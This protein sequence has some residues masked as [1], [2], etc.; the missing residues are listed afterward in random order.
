MHTRQKNQVLNIIE[1]M[2][3]EIVDT[4]S[5]LVRIRSVNPGYPGAN[6]E[7]ELGGESEAN[8]YLSEHYKLSLIHI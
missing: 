3:N 2:E 4:V 1:G 6:Y 7:E 8:S 5:Q